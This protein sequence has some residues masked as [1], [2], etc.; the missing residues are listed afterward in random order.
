MEA[1]VVYV[2]DGD[3]CD[4]VVIMNRRLERFKCRLALIDAPEMPNKNSEE[5]DRVKRRK[6]KKAKIA[7]DFL[8]W[9]CMGIDP[10]DFSGTD[11]PLSDRELQTKLD[12]NKT[13]VYADFQKPDVY[14]RPIVVLRNDREADKSFNDLLVEHDYAEPYKK[15]R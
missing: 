13:L 11:Q 5:S 7:R 2:Y 10:D 9:L 4:L 15:K 1:K 12:R 8:A 14:G 3:T 6:E